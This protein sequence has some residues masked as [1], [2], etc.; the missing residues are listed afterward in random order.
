MRIATLPAAA[1]LLAASAA[2]VLLAG[3]SGSVHVGST[4]KVSKDEL[5][6]TVSEELAATTGRPEP[7]ITCPEDLEAE[8]GKKTRCTLT[9]DDGS[10]IGVS[11]NVSSVEGSQ[12][13]FDIKVDDKTSS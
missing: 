12:V 8:V 2:C 4:Q 3:C 9:A 11:V 7:R 13:N 6:T 10:T 1:S 5:A